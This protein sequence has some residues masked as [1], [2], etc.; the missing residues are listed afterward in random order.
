MSRETVRLIN[1]VNITGYNIEKDI[2]DDIE[3]IKKEKGYVI[4]NYM[5]WVPFVKSKKIEKY[6]DAL[7]ISDFVF[8]DGVG[9]LT[10]IK[11]LY[12]KKLKNLNGTDL[13]PKLIENFKEKEYKIA[14]YGTSKNNLDKCRENLIKKGINIYYTQDGFSK[15]NFENI[16]KDTVLFVGMGSPIQ[17]IWVKENIDKIIEKNLIVVTVGGYFDFEAGYYKR[18]PEWIRKMKM[19]WIYRIID[20]PRKHLLKY[21]NN[22]YFFPYVLADKIK[23]VLKKK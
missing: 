3:K 20:N 1:G 19:E 5:Y 6:K 12:G 10:Y 21:M 17:E 22:L 18:A 11:V 13:N 2:Y 9:L 14:L 15:L 4:A 8:P 16:E 7:D 23:I